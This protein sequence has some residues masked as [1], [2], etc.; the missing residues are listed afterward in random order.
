MKFEKLKNLRAEKNFALAD[1]AYL[2]RAH[3][4]IKSSAMSVCNWEN[5]KQIP[6]AKTFMALC[7][8]FGVGPEYF[9]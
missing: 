9:E 5:G 3:H 8:I 6:N 1:V 2:L 7:K 4:K